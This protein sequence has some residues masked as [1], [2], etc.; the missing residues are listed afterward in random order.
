MASPT[1]RAPPAA[2]WPSLVAW[3]LACAAA[4][5]IGAFASIEAKTFY[6]ELARPAWAPP[7]GVF[8]PVWTVLY[9][10]MGVAAWLVWREREAPSRNAALTLFV[11]QLAVN[12]LWSWLFFAW[13]RGALAF[14][15]I[16]VLLVLIVATL[17]AFWRIRPLAGALLLPYLGWVGF[18][19]ALCYRVWQDN[20]AALG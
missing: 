5:A 17:A 12:A 2:S 4:G 8:G 16:L 3:L 15:D 1:L 19:T 9:A 14:L 11:V 6:A 10:L 20:P 13:H 18:A 7:A